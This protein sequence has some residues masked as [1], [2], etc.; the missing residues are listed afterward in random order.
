MSDAV[1]VCKDIKIKVNSSI[2]NEAQDIQILVALA[3]LFD[4]KKIIKNTESQ[5]Q[6]L[7]GKLSGNTKKILGATFKNPAYNALRFS[8]KF[9][10]V[11]DSITDQN[12]KSILGRMKWI[13]KIAERKVDKV[14]RNLSKL[15]KSAVYKRIASKQDDPSK[16]NEAIK[17]L[18]NKLSP[19]LRV[20]VK[21]AKNA[22]QVRRFIKGICL[23]HKWIKPRVRPKAVDV[24]NGASKKKPVHRFDWG[25]KVGGGYGVRLSGHDNLSVLAG[26]NRGLFGQGGLSGAYIND[27]Y[28]L[29]LQLDYRTNVS[30]EVAGKHKNDHIVSN[31]DDL[32]LSLFTYPFKRWSLFGQV[33]YIHSRNDYP[34]ERTEDYQHA[35]VANLRSNVL[36]SLKYPISINID[37]SFMVGTVNQAFPVETD[38]AIRVLVNGGLS[39]AI[40]VQQIII[41]PFI[42]GTVGYLFDRDLRV[43]GGYAGASLVV[44][45]HEANLMGLY[46][47]VEG[48]TLNIR[49]LYNRDKWGIGGRYFYNWYTKDHKIVDTVLDTQQT[50]GAEIFGMWRPLQFKGKDIEFKLFV[51]GAY[52]DKSKAGNVLAGFGFRWGT[53]PYALPSIFRPDSLVP[54]PEDR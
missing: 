8:D 5:I 20:R 17:L 27:R 44:G 11:I 34:S 36:L 40:K 10:V 25:V 31:L 30:W 23:S 29:K 14:L 32:R 45:N 28:R 18:T 26:E 3:E 49:Y 51:R 21:T 33:G 52:E 41:T 48:V 2:K 16:I 7:V 13:A 46:N 15:F 4:A 42:G 50:F 19:T 38:M 43:L 37:P 6:P 39:Y 1:Q 12:D 9:Q 47:N 24:T 35:F 22:A 54:L 53:L